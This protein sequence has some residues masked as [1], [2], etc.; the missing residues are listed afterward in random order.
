VKAIL[1]VL[2]ALYSAAA[3]SAASITVYFEER[4][5]YQMRA[6]T[7]VTGLVGTTAAQVFKAA[8]VPVVW[9]ATSMSRQMHM[10]RENIGASC[11]IGWYKN[12]ERQAYA[13]FTKPIFRD[14]PI[15]ALVRRQSAFGPDT[16]VHRLLTTP[17][18]RVLLRGKYSYGSLID[19]ALQRI[20][21]HTLAS[22]L[23]NSQ[24]VELLLGNR[25]DLMFASEEEAV[26]LLSHLADKARH[27]QVLRFSDVMPGETRHIACTRNVPDHTIERLNSAIAFK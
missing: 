20:K 4:A 24:L 14:G 13:K 1:T 9:E 19:G 23:P 18:L 25:G 26:L 2:M 6:D 11:V 10:L 3:L 22:P 7:S 8:E 27:L 17:G 15:V 5:P 16:S 12:S 21:P